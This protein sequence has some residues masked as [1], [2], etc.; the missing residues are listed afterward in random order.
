MSPL[1][2]TMTPLSEWLDLLAQTPLPAQERESVERELRIFADAVSSQDEA[3]LSASIEALSSLLARH[4]IP[5]L[6][7]KVLAV[8]VE[9]TQDTSRRAFG[10]LNLGTSHADLG[11]HSEARLAFER[12][13]ATFRETNHTEGAASVL[14]GQGN[15]HRALSEFA[16][17]R[18]AY[19]QALAQTKSLPK[20]LRILENWIGLEL[21]ESRHGPGRSLC[22]EWLNLAEVDD[23][24]SP[25]LPY[26]LHDYGLIGRRFLISGDREA[27]ESI[28]TRC[29]ELSARAS[30]NAE[31]VCAEL[32]DELRRQ[33]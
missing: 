32:F 26:V 6:Q 13:L 24:E 18:A 3:V 31:V 29:V 17:A 2:Q 14:L 27:A 11:Q 4:S 7:V 10:W 1:A 23:F 16:P 21:D 28:A 22:E 15:I 20:K 25:R 12:A 19:E 30:L 9:A 8:F 5:A 33:Q